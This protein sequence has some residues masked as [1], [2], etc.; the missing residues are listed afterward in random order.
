MLIVFQRELD[1]DSVFSVLDSVNP[2]LQNAYN[3]QQW[4][5]AVQRFDSRLHPAETR[6]SMKLHAHL[7]NSAVMSG[8]FDGYIKRDIIYFSSPASELLYRF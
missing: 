4:A 2:L 6:V 3:D 8:D 1:I 5:A 7:K